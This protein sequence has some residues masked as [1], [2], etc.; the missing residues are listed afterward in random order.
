MFDALLPTKLYLPPVRPDWVERTRLLAQLETT[1]HTRLI[2][3]SAPAGYGKTTLVTSWLQY[4]KAAGTAQICWLSLDE[5]DSDPRQFFRYLAV[6]VAPLPGVQSALLQLLQADQTLPAKTLM[7]AFVQDVT[8]V[9][10]PFILVLD[11]YHVVDSQQIDQTLDFLLDYLPPQMHLVITTREDP[12]LPLARLRARGQLIELRAADLRFTIEEAVAFLNQTMGLELAAK[13]AASLD[14]RTEGWIAGLQ[15][16]ALSMQGRQDVHEFIGAFAGDNRYVVDYLVEEVLQRQPEHVRRFLL[17]TSILDRL[18]GPLCDAVTLREDGKRTLETLERSNLFVVPLDDKRH[19]FRYHHLF[20]DVLQ[21]R[22]LEEQPNQAPT[23]HLRAS[24][25]YEQN[26]LPAD[27]VRHALAAKD[28]ERAATLIELAWRAMDQSLQSAAWLGWAK[29]LPDELVYTRP[30]LSVGYAWALLDG[31]KLD[32][33]EARLQDAERWLNKATDWSERMVTPSAQMVVAD[34][35]EFQ[36]LPG[37]IA[38]ARAYVAQARGDLADTMKYARQAL[39]LFSEDA[40]LKRAVPGALLGLAHWANGELEAAY[41]ALGD[42]MTA[43]QKAGNILLGISGTFGLADIRVAQG[44]L[45]EAISIYEHSLRLVTTEGKPV[46][47]GTADLHLGLSELYAEQGKLAAAAKHLLKSEALGKQDS[48]M[49]F[50]YHWCLAQA[51]QK[52][53]EGDFAGALV[54]LDQAEQMF[55]EIHI[56]DVRPAAALKARGLLAHGKVKDALAWARERGLSTSD[57][58]SY[59]REFEHV[60]L[61]RILIAQYRKDGVVSAI[62]KASGLLA[63]L[64]QE[65]ETRGRMGSAIEILALQAL[66]YQARGDVSAA[67]VALERALKL[68]EPEG[69]VRLFV[70]EGKPMAALL[71]EELKQGTALN[72]VHLLL[73]AFDEVEGE[74]AVDQPPVEHSLPDP[75]TERELEVLRLLE[76]GLSGPEIARELVISLNTMRTHTK[77]IY[78]KLGVNSR[79]MAVRRAE[80]LNIL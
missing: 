64:L 11:D 23:W 18:S 52:E 51:R 4:L 15:L 70:D 6:A 50:E 17:Q 69:Y 31:G 1:P 26:N 42:S 32:E 33:A 74:K 35:N 8:A 61:A 46:I 36:S 75:L 14:I 67:L 71:N 56:P 41:Q 25:W 48:Q 10:T 7:K 77:N 30:V 62:H 29:G 73:S 28:F 24:Q 63:R 9:K 27:A 16:A 40:F 57:D 22:A 47:Q 19:W 76:T 54:L 43:F 37:T 59:L 66:A 39:D 12:N 55:R 44:R 60:T 79:R 53:A 2:L 21:A 20:A 13:D 68:A 80:E 5:D 34:E 45:R 3:V 49:V 65:A 78:S 38:A 58:L 72:Y